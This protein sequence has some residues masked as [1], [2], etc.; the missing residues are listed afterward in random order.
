MVS[1]PL[2]AMGGMSTGADLAEQEEEAMLTLCQLV[3]PEFEILIHSIQ[4]QQHSIVGD[5]RQLQG[6]EPLLC[7]GL[8]LQSYAAKVLFCSSSTA[9]CMEVDACMAHVNT[10]EKLA[11]GRFLLE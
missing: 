8:L 10:R 5:L 2:W 3:P 11:R 9:V 1:T 4:I 6:G 7:K